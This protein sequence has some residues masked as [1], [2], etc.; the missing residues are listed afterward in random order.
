MTRP[1][2]HTVPV[3]VLA[4][5]I[6]SRRRSPELRALVRQHKPDLVVVE[7]A[8]RARRFLRKLAR[9][10]GYVHHQYPK[11]PGAEWTGIAVL[12]RNNVDIVRTKPLV[13]DRE[14]TG[15]KAGKRHDPRVYPTLVL[16]KHGVTFRAVGIHFP[17]RNQPFAQAESATEIVQYVRAHDN[18]PVILAGDWNMIERELQKIADRC[19]ATVLTG[20]T[21]VDHALVARFEDHHQKRLP[22]PAG[23]HGWALYRATI[24]C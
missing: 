15:P 4:A 21:K 17:T 23:A 11:T 8:F 9:G 12:V 5:N 2:Q 20:H 13:M 7:Q 14:W 6:E 16:R 1:V 10:H 18:S 3:E 24:A 22:T 19:A